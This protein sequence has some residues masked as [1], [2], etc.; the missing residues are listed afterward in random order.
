MGKD[1]V[2]MLSMTQQRHFDIK[3]SYCPPLKDGFTQGVYSYFKL[4][5]NLICYDYIPRP[6]ITNQHN[7][8]SIL[9]VIATTIF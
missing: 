9:L 7:A 3:S 4:N 6:S 2:R 1:T 5:S 8:Q